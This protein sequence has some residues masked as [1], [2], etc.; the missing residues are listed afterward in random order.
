MPIR[1]FCLPS[2]WCLRWCHQPFQLWIRILRHFISITID[3]HLINSTAKGRRFSTL[4]C[5]SNVWTVIVSLP[6]KDTYTQTK[7]Q[8]WLL[9]KSFDGVSHE[10]LVY[11]T[12]QGKRAKSLGPTR[13]LYKR[14]RDGQGNERCANMKKYK[15]HPLFLFCNVHHLE[16][17]KISSVVGGSDCS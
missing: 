2:S 1:P 6:H 15:K 11:G 7:R 14:R 3:H 13:I 10:R 9:I 12:F 4:G 16:V 8:F 17:G 5:E